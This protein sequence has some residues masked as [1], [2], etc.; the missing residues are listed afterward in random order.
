MSFCIAI[1]IGQWDIFLHCLEGRRRRTIRIKETIGNLRVTIKNIWQ[2]VE[3]VK[4]RYHVIEIFRVHL[5][6]VGIARKEN[7]SFTFEFEW[8][9]TSS[10]WPKE[11]SCLILRSRNSWASGNSEQYFAYIRN[12]SCHLVNNSTIRDVRP[13]SFRPAVRKSS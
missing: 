7:S 9:F 10:F 8:L 2:C 3:M 11:L 12:L 13:F 6:F 5:L 1:G 4:Q